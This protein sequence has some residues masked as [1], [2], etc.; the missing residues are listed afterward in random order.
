MDFK[1]AVR[2][3]IL[4][5]EGA[6]KC[7]CP[8]CGNVAEVRW[9]GHWVKTLR[10]ECLGEE[11][12]WMKWDHPCDFSMDNIVQDD[13]RLKVELADMARWNPNFR[14]TK[15]DLRARRASE[16]GHG[17]FEPSTGDEPVL[18]DGKLAQ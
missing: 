1:D 11:V 9:S 6:Q 3:Q 15:E 7:E 17:G 10:A 13:T 8:Q 2:N 16:Q 5:G 12:M 14:R 4:R 18:K